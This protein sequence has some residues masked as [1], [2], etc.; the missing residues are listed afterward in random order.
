MY[1][2]SKNSRELRFYNIIKSVRWVRFSRRVPAEIPPLLYS[3]N[4]PKIR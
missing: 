2:I 3:N 1:Q 4:H